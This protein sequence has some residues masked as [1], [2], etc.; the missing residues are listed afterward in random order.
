MNA[1]SDA[2]QQKLTELHFL[3]MLCDLW[4]DRASLPCVSALRRH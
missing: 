1:L 3:Y 2:N 4:K